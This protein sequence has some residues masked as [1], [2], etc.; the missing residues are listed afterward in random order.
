MTTLRRYADHADWPIADY[1]CT[2]PGRFMP[3]GG[4]SIILGD[5]DSR[6]RHYAAAGGQYIEVDLSRTILSLTDAVGLADFIRDLTLQM[7]NIY[8]SIE[9]YSGNFYDFRNIEDNEIDIED[10]AHS[11]SMQCR[12]GGHCSEFYSIAEH[13]VRASFI[14]PD[15][16][17]FDKL[18]HDAAESVAVDLPTPF[19]RLLRD[20]TRILERIEANF[21]D[22]FGHRHPL[23]ESV[24]HADLTMLATEKRDLKKTNNQWGM[25]EGVPTLPDIIQPWTQKQAKQAFLDRYEQLKHTA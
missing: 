15:H 14:D 22:V 3:N 4:G 11:L 7:G 17:A 24:K 18:M 1:R 5:L 6:G 21:A 9:L 2:Y 19:K 8:P 10:V 23:P 20:Y 13:S 12:F 25:L 16:D